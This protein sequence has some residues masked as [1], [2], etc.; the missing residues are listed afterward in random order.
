MVDLDHPNRIKDVL[1]TVGKDVLR[2]IFRQWARYGYTTRSVNF[3]KEQDFDPSDLMSHEAY[4]YHKVGNSGWWFLL[5]PDLI[6]DGRGSKAHRD[7]IKERDA[8]IERDKVAGY[9]GG[10]DFFW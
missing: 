9:R 6:P 8:A 5:I 2:Q 10:G 1:N 4:G 3:V 7:M